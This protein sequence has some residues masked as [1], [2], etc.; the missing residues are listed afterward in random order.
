MVNVI[1]YTSK[2]DYY[3][4]IACIMCIYLV[5][6]SAFSLY[7]IVDTFKS[8]CL[9]VNK[10]LVRFL[11]GN[12]IIFTA[13]KVYSVWIIYSFSHFFDFNKLTTDL[14]EIPVW[15]LICIFYTRINYLL[16]DFYL[17]MDLSNLVTTKLKII[18]ILSIC[19]NL[20]QFIINLTLVLFQNMRVDI[21]VAIN[22]AFAIFPLIAY[23]VVYRLLSTKINK[24]MPY[25]L[26]KNV[27]K[28]MKLFSL[29]PI[30]SFIAAASIV[31]IDYIWDDLNVLEK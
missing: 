16:F 5:I 23:L 3:I 19:Y 28:G 20:L 26:A 12:M 1:T 31:P 8:R 10:D 29:I 13:C 9:S 25:S 27:L 14:L 18:K 11:L 6:L 22:Y 15:C 2:D 7:K 17:S 4:V 24:L 30:L 21:L